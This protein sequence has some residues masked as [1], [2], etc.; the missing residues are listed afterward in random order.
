MN[1]SPSTDAVL[2]G[3]IQAIDDEILPALGNAKAQA[4]AVMI[5]SMLQGLRQKLPTFDRVIVEEHNAMLQ[6][7]RD[8]AGQLAGVDGPAAVRVR[9]RAGTLGQHPELPEPPDPGTIVEA[10]RELGR[11]LE[12]TMID[13]DELQRA[14]VAGADRALEIVRAHFGPRFVRYVEVTTVG[15]GFIGRS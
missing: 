9:D 1:T 15:Q 13:I 12:H 10:H 14:G 2:E 11:A 6:V 3:V 4:T 5:Q 7:L 8:V